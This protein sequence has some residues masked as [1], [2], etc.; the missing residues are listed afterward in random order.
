MDNFSF[1][2]AFVGL[3]SLLAFSQTSRHLAVNA[4]SRWASSL[5]I[6]AAALFIWRIAI[7]IQWWTILTFVIMSFIVG[8]LNH[9]YAR[10]TSRGALFA[11]Q[12]VQASIW[13]LALPLSWLQLLS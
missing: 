11:L 12:P 4:F 9:S 6:P 13:L 8:I 1:V 7:D 2:C 10:R 3:G 5:S